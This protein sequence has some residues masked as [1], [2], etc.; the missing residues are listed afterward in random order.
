MVYA[1]AISLRVVGIGALVA[2][3]AGLVAAIAALVQV[4]RMN[5]MAGLR[6]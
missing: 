4:F 2:L 5:I 6:N 3:T 1:I